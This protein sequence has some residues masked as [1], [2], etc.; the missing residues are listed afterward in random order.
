MP[1]DAAALPSPPDIPPWKDGRRPYSVGGNIHSNG[2]VTRPD[3]Y[4]NGALPDPRPRFPN[5]KDLQDQAALLDVNETTPV[6]MGTVRGG[7]ICSP[8]PQ[9][10]ILL[11][12]AS[13]AIDLAKKLADTE[14]GQA[15]V[16]YLRASEI[17]V[18]TIPEHP[19]YRTTTFPHPEW[20]KDFARLMMVCP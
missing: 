15:Y 8:D 5:I 20:P 10:E 14:P 12:T 13:E 4:Q 17:T 1:T 3:S 6:S 18:N 2:Q 11:G 19:D 16:Q 7:D 9:L